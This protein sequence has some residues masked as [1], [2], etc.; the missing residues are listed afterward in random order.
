MATSL[1]MATTADLIREPQLV[2]PHVFGRFSFERR[3]QLETL[4]HAAQPLI[5]SVAMPSMASP[6]HETGFAMAFAR[7]SPEGNSAAK[8]P[9]ATDASTLFSP[10]V[11]YGRGS[12]NSPRWSSH[13]SG[14]SSVSLKAG[15]RMGFGPPGIS[16]QREEPAFKRHF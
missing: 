4:N 15:T 16:W 12:A 3:L 5:S 11:I 6:R 13:F 1:P 10:R 2:S 14:G 8:Q 7:L 9:F